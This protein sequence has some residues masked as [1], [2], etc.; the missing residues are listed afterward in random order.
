MNLTTLDC[1]LRDGGYYNNWDFS[2]ALVDKYIEK[3]IESRIDV[4]EIGFRN[5]S[6]DSFLGAYA[7]SLDE[8]IKLKKNIKNIKIGV[9]SDASIFFS[10]KEKIRDQVKKLYLPKSRSII[11][12]VRIAV[13]FKDIDRCY[14]IVHTLKELGYQVGFNMMQ[15]GGRSNKEIEKATSLIASWNLVDVLYFADSL[16]NMSP[17][18]V[19]NV[20]RLIKNNWNKEIG[21]HTHDNKGMAVNNTLAAI[22]NGVTWVDSTVRGMGRGAG[23]AKSEE[24]L[25]ELNRLRPNSYVF[26]GLKKLSLEDFQ[27]LFDKYKWGASELYSLA[28]DY[29]IH[30]TYIQEMVSDVRYSLKQVRDI[31]EYMK[32]IPSTSYNQDT[33]EEM[34]IKSKANKNGSWNAKNWC[35]GKDVMLIGNGPSIKT[36]QKQILDFINSKKLLKLAINIQETIPTEYIDGIVS[37]NKSRI[38]MDSKFYSN[39]NKP[40]Y[41]PQDLISDIPDKNNIIKKINDYGSNIVKGSF[42]INQTSCSIPFQLTAIYALA[43]VTVGGARKIYLAGFDGYNDIKLQNEMLT[44][45]K[46]YQEIPESVK[47]IS[48]TPTSYGLT[49][50]DQND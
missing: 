46:L 15:V 33:L 21:I 27:V 35:L 4:I 41:M 24:L 3:I 30:P 20:V 47:L 10:S 1:T 6:N 9:M 2:E 26:E 12:L 38:L 43:L 13:H 23:N 39:L 7:Y 17:N 42:Q 19:I 8:H 18:D 25:V 32:D 37:S 5:F 14:D 34:R 16:G 22:S 29:N 44:S 50:L 49:K 11:S 36:H 40:L 45:L 28:A 48:V 31:I